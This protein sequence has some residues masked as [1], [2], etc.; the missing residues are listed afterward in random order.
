[1]SSRDASLKEKTPF[2]IVPRHDA[3]RRRAARSP[4]LEESILNF[5]HDRPETQTQEL[6]FITRLSS[7]P[8]L[9]PVGGTT[10][11]A[12][13]GA[14]SCSEQMFSYCNCTLVNDAFSKYFDF[15]FV[16]YFLRLC[17]TASLAPIRSY[18]INDCFNV[19]YLPLKF[20]R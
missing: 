12:A 2:A 11:Y 16:F 8:E 14:S 1:M 20:S 4:N 3:G 18:T 5:V 19:L 17:L 6:L 13:A 9:P 10:M 15:H 7:P